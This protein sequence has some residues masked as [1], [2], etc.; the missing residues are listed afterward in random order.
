MLSGLTALAEIALG[1]AADDVQGQRQVD[2][3]LERLD[4]YRR[5]FPIGVPA[6]LSWRAQMLEQRK[7]PRAA[8]RARELARA[9]ALKLQMNPS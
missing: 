6:H 5:V 1:N 9:A 7:Q 2:I 4:A 3:T 8:A